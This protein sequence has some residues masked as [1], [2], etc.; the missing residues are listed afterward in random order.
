MTQFWLTFDETLQSLK[1]LKHNFSVFSD[2][3]IDTKNHNRKEKN[4][5]KFL[6]AF[7]VE[8]REFTTTGV[9]IKSKSCIDHIF[10]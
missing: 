3:N 6:T 5:E 4:Y 2:L 9:T 1:S 10:S 7:D 8:V